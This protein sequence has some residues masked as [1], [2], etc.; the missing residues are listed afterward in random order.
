[1]L[2]NKIVDQTLQTEA[3]MLPR[4]MPI[5]CTHFD[6]GQCN[7][8][9]GLSDNIQSSARS[10]IFKQAMSNPFTYTIL[11]HFFHGFSQQTNSLTPRYDTVNDS[12]M[13]SELS[14]ISDTSSTISKSSKTTYLGLNAYQDI[15]SSLLVSLLDYDMINP[16]SKL[17]TRKG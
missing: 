4:L 9:D 11:A 12:R 2:A 16:S 15:G 7:L 5:N 17:L 13:A 14:S 1:M 6:F 3:M 8:I 10:V